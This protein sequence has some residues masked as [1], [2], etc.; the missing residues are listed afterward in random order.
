MTASLGMMIAASGHR[1][2]SI[3]R[4]IIEAQGELATANLDVLDRNLASRRYLAGNEYTLADI[5][6]F[7]WYGALVL[8]NQ[9]SPR[10]GLIVDPTRTG[11]MKLFGSYARYYESVPLDMVDR[12]FPGEPGLRSRH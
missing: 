7:P 12:S 5:A 9:W 3:G 2:G 6:T 8:G 4:L 1:Y 11:R 10:L